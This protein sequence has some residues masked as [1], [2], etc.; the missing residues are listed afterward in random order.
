MKCP[1]SP[2]C[3]AKLCMR[4]AF[5]G[6]LALVGVAHYMTLSTFKEMVA[7]GLGPI[8]MLGTVWAYVLP[9]LM[10]VG[11]VLIVIK[12]KPDVAAWAAGVAL[13]S[14]AV[15]MLL[16]P[17]LGGVMLSEVMGAVNNSF[18]WLLV[19]AMVV[20]CCLAPCEKGGG[21]P[22]APEGHSCPSC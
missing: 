10:I 18:I 13:A 5:G 7:G 8:A 3:I 6:A 19:Y 16:K 22:S 15:G 4:V 9:A 11:G 14:I 1:K 17:V 21:A 12:Q 20:K 2:K